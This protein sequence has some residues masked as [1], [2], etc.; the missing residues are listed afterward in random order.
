M[1]AQ[2]KLTL[3]DLATNGTATF[4]VE[5]KGKQGG[6]HTLGVCARSYGRNPGSDDD[7]LLKTSV[8]P[9]IWDEDGKGSA[10]CFVVEGA[11]R[12]DAYVFEGNPDHTRDADT[13]A[14]SNVVE[15]HP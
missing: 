3:Q 4:A 10:E 2:A 5:H 6:E 1:S 11:V 8:S 9:V 12:A 13:V 7:V 15:L 14:V